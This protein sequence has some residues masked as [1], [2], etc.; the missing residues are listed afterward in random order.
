[1]LLNKIIIGLLTYDLPNNIAR[2]INIDLN[3]R[4]C[5]KIIKNSNFYKYL[6]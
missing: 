3:I 5:I 1:M 6:N 2:Y 4:I